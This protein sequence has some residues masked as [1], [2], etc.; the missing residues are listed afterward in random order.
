MDNAKFIALYTPFAQNT[1]VQ[2]AAMLARKRRGHFYAGHF[3]AGDYAA[4]AK[5]L[6]HQVGLNNRRLAPLKARMS[7]EAGVEVFPQGWVHL[8]HALAA[9]RRSIVKTY[10]LRAKPR[11]YYK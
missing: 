4:R 2:Q 9:L 8:D 1:G 5:A 6:E 11:S 7:A 10:G 3:Y